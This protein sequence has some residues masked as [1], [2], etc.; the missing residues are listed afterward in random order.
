MTCSSFKKPRGREGDYLREHLKDRG[1]TEQTRINQRG[2]LCLKYH[3]I[4]TTISVLPFE[5]ILVDAV[6]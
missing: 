6:S 4:F 3:I 5:T 1:T 2:G